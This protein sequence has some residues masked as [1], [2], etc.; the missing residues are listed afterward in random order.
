MNW[1]QKLLLVRLCSGAGLVL[2][3]VGCV[4]GA[5]SENKFLMGFS[6]FL[7]FVSLLGAVAANIGMRIIFNWHRAGSVGKGEVVNH[8]IWRD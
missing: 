1:S 5:G 7:A 2:A 6:M 8:R 3:F 4:A